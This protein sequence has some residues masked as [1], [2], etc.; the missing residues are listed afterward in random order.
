MAIIQTD[1]I[2]KGG[3]LVQYEERL[4]S[5]LQHQNIS[6]VALNWEHP[7]GLAI[8]HDNATKTLKIEEGMQKMSIR[9]MKGL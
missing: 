4:E 2:V 3:I 6:L 1:L 5:H 7:I 9:I 8:I